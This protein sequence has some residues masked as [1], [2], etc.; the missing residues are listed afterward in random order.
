M[1]VSDEDE[2]EDG[3]FDDDN[4]DDFFSL[5]VNLAG[6]FFLP[7]MIF[8]NAFSL[9][10]LLDDGD[11]VVVVVVFVVVESFSGLDEPK[12]FGLE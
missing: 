10:F 2:D 3:P 11:D 4:D 9:L 6:N 8:L 1:I 7:D 5:N 12:Y